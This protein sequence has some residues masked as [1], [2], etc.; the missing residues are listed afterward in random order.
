MA[1]KTTRAEFQDVFPSLVQDLLG[2]AKKFNLPD[3]ALSWF[4]KVASEHPLYQRH[5]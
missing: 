5:R 4:E 3:N 1:T 2:E